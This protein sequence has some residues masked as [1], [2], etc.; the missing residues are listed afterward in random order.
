VRLK[1]DEKFAKTNIEK[2]NLI[3]DKNKADKI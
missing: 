1:I 3:K 2:Y